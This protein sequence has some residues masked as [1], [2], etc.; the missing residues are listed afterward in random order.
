MVI[1]APLRHLTQH[2]QRW[3]IS[4][5][6]VFN[7]ESI[8]T[9]EQRLKRQVPQLVI[10]H[11]DEI[12]FALELCLRRFEQQFVELEGRGAKAQIALSKPLAKAFGLLRQVGSFD[13]Y[14]EDLHLGCRL[15]QRLANGEQ[16]SYLI[17][18]DVFQ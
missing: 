12:G 8:R 1:R 4:D 5:G 16:V 6:G 17:R 3:R 10:R 7:Q 15:A 18:Y 11:D 14:G 9:D 13:R 2:C